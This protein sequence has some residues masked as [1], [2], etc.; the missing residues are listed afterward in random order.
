MRFPGR[1]LS[2]DKPIPYPFRGR[3]EHATS[4]D[5]EPTLRILAASLHLALPVD[6]SE[7]ADPPARSVPV[8]SDAAFYLSCSYLPPFEIIHVS[9]S[10][11]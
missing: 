7:E 2:S 10:A 3:R 1:P 9:N 8:V 4:E 11:Y 6:L 5:M